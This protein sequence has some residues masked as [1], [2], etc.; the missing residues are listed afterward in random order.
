MSSD[1]FAGVS[2]RFPSSSAKV[3]LGIVVYLGQLLPDPGQGLCLYHDFPAQVFAGS[4]LPARCPAL[5]WEDVEQ[6]CSAHEGGQGDGSC[7]PSLSPTSA[8]PARRGPSTPTLAKPL[9]PHAAWSS[10]NSFW[11][12]FWAGP[13]H[14]TLKATPVSCSLQK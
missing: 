10:C 11:G 2:V 8:H 5:A 1:V 13:L 4:P 12:V 9:Q 6:V 14:Y 7:K 3:P